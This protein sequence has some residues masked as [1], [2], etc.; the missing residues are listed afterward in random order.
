MPPYRMKFRGKRLIRRSAATGQG[1]VLQS[2]DPSRRANRWKA[3]DEEDGGLRDMIAM[4]GQ[5]YLERLS[6]VEPWET[7]KL[8]KLAMANRITQ[9]LDGF[10][11]SVIDRKS[12][13]LNSSH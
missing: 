12:T 6:Q 13:R 7:E 10:V 11:R 8:S 4:L 2:D 5:T 9:Q 3:F 1:V